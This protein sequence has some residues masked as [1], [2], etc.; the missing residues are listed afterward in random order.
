MSDENTTAHKITHNQIVRL[1]IENRDKTCFNSSQHKI[2]NPKYLY[3]TR[4][5][6]DD[7]VSSRYCLDYLVIHDPLTSSSVSYMGLEVIFLEA[8]GH[9]FGHINLGFDYE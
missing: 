3:I 4:R 1:L 9:N 8:N 6:F 5:D 2:R 7:L